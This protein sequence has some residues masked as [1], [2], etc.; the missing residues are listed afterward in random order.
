[1]VLVFLGFAC[2]MLVGIP[3]SALQKAGQAVAYVHVLQWTQNLVVMMLVPLVWMRLV[4]LPDRNPSATGWADAWRTLGLARVEWRPMLL[5]FCLMLA[6][7]PLFD[8]LEVASYRCPLPD[9]LRSYCETEFL[10]NQAVIVQVLQP[11]GIWG[12]LELVL[13]MCVS[14]ALG[15]EMLFRGA[16]LQCFQ[17]YTSLNRH[18]I[19]LLVG[20]IFSLIHFELYG[21]LPRWVLGTLFVYVVLAT[22]SLWPAV[23]MHATNNLIALINYKLQLHRGVALADVLPSERSYT[24][25][26]PMVVLSAV[27][28]V[29]L[30]WLLLRS[31]KHENTSRRG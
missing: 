6:A 2:C 19:A 12:W 20:L 10:M 30:L 23:V 11:G 4:L 16:L 26:W 25:S 29:L 21:L 18:A 9:G 1:M 24:F 14:T 22:G 28:S 8:V 13:L 27:T 17:Q 5:A 15:E 31:Q 7:V 3:A